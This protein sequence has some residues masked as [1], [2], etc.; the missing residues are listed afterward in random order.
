M[1]RPSAGEREDLA[2][3]LDGIAR[4]A[5]KAA[6][7]NFEFADQVPNDPQGASSTP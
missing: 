3:L 1:G 7:G 6:E 4:K 2:D 5:P